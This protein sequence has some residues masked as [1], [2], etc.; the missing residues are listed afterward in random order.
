[1]KIRYRVFWTQKDGNKPIEYEDAF[2][3]KE[4]FRKK[5][6]DTIAF[7]IA[8][9]VSNSFESRVWANILVSHFVQIK[10]INPLFSVRIIREWNKWKKQYVEDRIKNNN[11][12][13]WYEEE[14]LKK[15][16]SSTLLGLLISK[17]NSNPMLTAISIGD[18]CLFLVRE[19]KLYTS[20]PITSP[21]GF[22]DFPS[23]VFLENVKKN[24]INIKEFKEKLH[25]GDRIYLLTDAIAEWFLKENDEQHKPW[26]TLS[27]I[28]TQEEFIK[29]IQRLR[30]K[31]KIKNDDVTCVYIKLY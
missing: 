28:K 4:P 5:L 3:P 2:A 16:P 25:S 1:M 29:F 17:E 19:E 30:R 7:A 11:P 9:G 21:S 12:L 20:F 27:N 23:Q 8:D 6:T 18:S 14:G 24:N 31:G 26:S 15:G 22:S 13:K 10:G